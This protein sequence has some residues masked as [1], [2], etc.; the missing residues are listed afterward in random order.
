MF[1]YYALVLNENNYNNID[2]LII[3]LTFQ[4]IKFTERIFVIII[5]SSS[6]RDLL[7]FYAF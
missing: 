6:T 7:N 5:N 4:I 3:K 2:D 1:I